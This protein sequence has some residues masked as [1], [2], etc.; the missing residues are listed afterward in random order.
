MTRKLLTN[1]ANCGCSRDNHFDVDPYDMGQAEQNAD[2]HF[3][4]CLDCGDCYE[5]DFEE[6]KLW[7]I[8]QCDAAFP[9]LTCLLTHRAEGSG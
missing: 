2:G 9:N 6:P 5:A 1:C 4:H 3:N 8:C 7:F